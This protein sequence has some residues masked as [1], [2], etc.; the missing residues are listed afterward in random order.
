MIDKRKLSIHGTLRLLVDGIID[1]DQAVNELMQPQHAEDLKHVICPQCKK[2]FVLT[3][4]YIGTHQSLII[5]SCPSG[6]I[7]DV[8][9]SCPHCDYEEEL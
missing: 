7:Y 2:G 8:C 3:F 4:D 9:I 1:T 6:G 5:R